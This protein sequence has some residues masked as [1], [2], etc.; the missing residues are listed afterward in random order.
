[1]SAHRI[2]AMAVTSASNPDN[3]IGVVT[4][5]DYMCKVGYLSKYL[6]RD[7]KN[8]T[9]KEI[10]THGDANLVTVTEDEHVDECMKKLLQRDIRHM[11]VR[12]TDGKIKYLCSVK[13]LVKCAVDRHEAVIGNMVKNLN[14]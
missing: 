9:V 8:V 11:L 13:D 7:D 1:M 6:S 12:G 14:L 5:R 4:E 3:V 10:C 2:G